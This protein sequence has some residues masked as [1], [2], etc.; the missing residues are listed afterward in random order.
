MTS[1][2]ENEQVVKHGSVT[3]PKGSHPELGGIKLEV[4]QVVKQVQIDP[5][6]LEWEIKTMRPETT[7]LISASRN[8]QGLETLEKLSTFWLL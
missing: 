8:L 2:T 5:Y 4:Q 1:L 6:K 7:W 3:D